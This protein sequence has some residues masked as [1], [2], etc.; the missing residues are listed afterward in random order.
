ML[1]KINDFNVNGELL[2]ADIILHAECPDGFQP[3][4][5]IIP[6]GNEQTGDRFL[7]N[8][9]PQIVKCTRN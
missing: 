6:E 4:Q 8:Q 9:R 1:I 3:I 7:L 5:I 2:Q